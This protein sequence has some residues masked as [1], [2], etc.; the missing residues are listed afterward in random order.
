MPQNRRD[1]LSLCSAASL[2][3]QPPPRIDPLTRTGSGRARNRLSAAT[4][5]AL[6]EAEQNPYWLDAL[7][8]IDAKPP[9]RRSAAVHRSTLVRGDTSRPWVALTFDDGPHPNSTRQ[10][11]DVLHD[12]RAPATFFVVGEM[13]HRYP[14]LIREQS[15]GGHS[16][17]NHT[18]HHV[19]LSKIPRRYIATE[20]KA[21]GEVVASVIGRAPR[22]FRPPGGDY[23]TEVAE[24]A[25][26]LGYRMVLW[27]SDPGDYRSP[28]PAVILKRIEAGLS[29]GAVILV[30]DGIRQTLEVLPEL[31]LMIRR[32]GLQLVTI[33]QMLEA[34]PAPTLKTQ[35]PGPLGATP[36]HGRE[37]LRPLERPPR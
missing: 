1:F 12:F 30:H 18:Y 17:G 27:T 10:I 13:A 20:I 14:E 4:A 37:S 24:L 6:E 32:R 28:G 5:L 19:S 9:R 36:P 29:P 21:C 34:P 2:Q 3:L 25:V 15:R 7:E 26:G 23:D 22:L 31:I 11:L 8:R 16:I 33:D 35:E